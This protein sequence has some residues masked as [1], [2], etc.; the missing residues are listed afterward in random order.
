MRNF[1]PTQFLTSAWQVKQFPADDGVEVAFAGRSNAG[2]SSALNAITGR[3][4][5][6][7]TSKTPG[8]TQLINYFSVGPRQRLADLPGYGYAKVPEKMRLH[9]RELMVRYVRTR[10]SLAGVV[11]V[12]DCRHP[13]TDFDW[14][15]LEWAQSHQLPAHLLLTKADKLGR[16]AGMATLQQVKNAVGEAA[17]AQLFSAMTKTG[18]DQARRQVMTWLSGPAPRQ[19][20]DESEIPDESVE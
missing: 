14:Q 5:L 3:K 4:D 6:A 18:V 13:L 9:W 1:P 7:R 20:S 10:A 2:K 16:G 12:M 19:L 8:R 11:I 15:M 17:S